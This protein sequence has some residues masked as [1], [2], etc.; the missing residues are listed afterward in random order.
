MDQQQINEASLLQRVPK[1][2]PGALMGIVKQTLGPKIASVVTKSIPVVGTVVALKGA[3]DK[4]KSVWDSGQS[5]KSG[6]IVGAGLDVAS[7]F[8]SF[9]TTIPATAYNM[10]RDLYSQ[11][12]AGPKGEMVTLEQDLVADPQGTKERLNSLVATI[13]DTI[14]KEVDLVMKGSQSQPAVA[15]R[16]TT[17]QPTTAQPTTAQPA[18]AQRPTTAQPKLAETKSDIS[19]LKEL[20]GL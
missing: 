10:A 5:I 19:R 20:A 1:V 2:N 16:P 8:G 3:Y 14:K 6:D 15:Q 7:T 18:V 9:V 17:A 13:T 11:A 12:F 4:L